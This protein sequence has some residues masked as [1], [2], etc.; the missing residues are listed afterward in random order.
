MALAKAS[1]LA[2]GNQ[3]KA[4][5]SAIT[6]KAAMDGVIGR[7]GVPTPEILHYNMMQPGMTMQLG[8]RDLVD[9]HTS[10]STHISASELRK[11][12]CDHDICPMWMLPK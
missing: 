11:A 6:P 4:P 5:Q 8:T 2:V 9:E 12:R 10:A 7:L 3:R 1:A